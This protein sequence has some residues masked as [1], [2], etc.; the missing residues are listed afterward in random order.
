VIIDSGTERREKERDATSI[1]GS[2]VPYALLAEFLAISSAEPQLGQIHMQ[3]S[4]KHTFLTY[5]AVMSEI[6][7]PYG[8][9]ID[10]TSITTLP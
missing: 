4:P 7:R 6:N 1:Q 5:R 10:N 3:H 9:I 8:Y 2:W